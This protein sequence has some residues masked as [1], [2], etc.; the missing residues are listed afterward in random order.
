MF[1]GEFISYLDMCKFCTE[2]IS[3]NLSMIPFSDYGL[4]KPFIY[5]YMERPS[6]HCEYNYPYVRWYVLGSTSIVS[7]FVGNTINY[8]IDFY[9]GDIRS[10]KEHDGFLNIADF[11]DKGKNEEN[12][13]FDEFEFFYV[14]IPHFNP[15]QE[16]LLHPTLRLSQQYLFSKNLRGKKFKFCCP[17]N[18]KDF[19]EWQKKENKNN[20]RILNKMIEK[21]EAT[22]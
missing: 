8:F 10:S 1:D 3:K 9:Y 22:T 21:K 12:I 2:N 15:E 20:S 5:P 11:F 7:P 14:T 16:N 6:P 13:V 19:S 4:Q 18:G 17:N